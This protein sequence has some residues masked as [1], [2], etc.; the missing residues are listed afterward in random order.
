[1]FFDG[2]IGP[3]SDSGD[4]TSI[5]S[6]LKSSV[7][8]FSLSSFRLFVVLALLLMASL[9]L[10][11]LICELGGWCLEVRDDRR[12]VEEA[13][14]VVP[15]L[16]CGNLTFSCLLDG[17]DAVLCGVGERAALVLLLASLEDNQNDANPKK[18]PRKIAEEVKQ[19]R[20]RYCWGSRVS[21]GQ[22]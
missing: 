4:L 16:F 22:L 11:L 6:F 20:Y 7:E 18:Q 8:A 12:C 3:S 9:G 1:M 14:G 21:A 13:T 19:M 5:S 17:M 10:L 2:C 15:E